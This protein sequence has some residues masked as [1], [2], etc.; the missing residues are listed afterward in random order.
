MIGGVRFIGEL[1][2]LE[3]SE[4]RREGKMEGFVVYSMTPEN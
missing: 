2:Y 3:I 1:Q 4:G